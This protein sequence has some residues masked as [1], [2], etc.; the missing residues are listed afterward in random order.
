MA[1][2]PKP[3]LENPVV[4]PTKI[5]QKLSAGSK[6]ERGVLAFSVFKSVIKKGKL[7]CVS[8]FTTL[9]TLYEQPG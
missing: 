8:G 2:I 3:F 1:K 4:M 5:V 6:S 7:S 9:V